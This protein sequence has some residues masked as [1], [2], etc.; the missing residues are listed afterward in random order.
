MCLITICEIA[1]ITIN[2]PN[3]K[4]YPFVFTLRCSPFMFCF[5]VENGASSRFSK[6][7]KL[8]LLTHQHYETTHKYL[9]L[10]IDITTLLALIIMGLDNHF[11]FHWILNTNI[12]NEIN[13]S[14][15]RPEVAW[16][17]IWENF[18]VFKSQ[19]A[20]QKKK[21][22][23]L[24][25]QKLNLCNGKIYTAN[26]LRQKKTNDRMGGIYNFIIVCSVKWNGFG[27]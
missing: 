12:S 3:D 18:A 7:I 25:L 4:Q 9:K 14:A 17:K 1:F 22:R 10:L 20:K 19:I 6:K 16:D 26:R 8:K 21:K 24:H 23:G 2:K 27:E 13:L 5:V 11:H 15:G